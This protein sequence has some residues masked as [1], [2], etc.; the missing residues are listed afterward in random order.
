ML[1]LFAD[2][3][4]GF[5][6]RNRKIACDS[7]GFDPLRAGA[8]VQFHA[9]AMAALGKGPFSAG[10]SRLTL[11][12][13]PFLSMVTRISADTCLRAPRINRRGAEGVAV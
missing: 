6:N 9:A 1:Y 11:V 5:W 3:N 4:S 10:G 13:F 12:T 2:A 7:T 8:N